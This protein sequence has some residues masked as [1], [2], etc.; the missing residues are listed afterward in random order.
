MK[1][2]KDEQPLLNKK[3]LLE[4]FS[5]KGGW[6]FARLPDIRPE[7]KNPFGWRKV[8]GTIDGYEISKYH[9][10]PMGDGNLFLPVKAEIRKKIGKQ[11]GDTVRVILYPDNE[12]LHV[13]EEMLECLKDEP[14]AYKFFQKL[15]ES[16]QRHYILW[17]YS[18][19]KEETKVNRLAKC[20]NRCSKQLKMYEPVSE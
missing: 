15:T 14:A 7:K 19:K 12:P 9:L 6:T 17:I 8:R 11:E 13:P 1:K 18:A 10:M 20:V 5:G 3:V 4:K 16:E 2:G